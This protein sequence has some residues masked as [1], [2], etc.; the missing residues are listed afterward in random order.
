MS[1]RFQNL[2]SNDSVV[3]YVSAIMN[4]VNCTAVFIV[5]A[6]SCAQNSNFKGIRHMHN[7]VAAFEICKNCENHASFFDEIIT[8]LCSGFTPTYND[9]PY[10]L[11][12][13]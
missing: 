6:M 2:K 8:E 11:W 12:L 3:G 7:Y 4:L 1:T 10:Q 5:L 13:L 9:Y